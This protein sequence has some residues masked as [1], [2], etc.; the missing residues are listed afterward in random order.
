MAHQDFS[1]ICP[2][3]KEGVERELVFGPWKASASADLI[4]AVLPPMGR[5]IQTNE[6]YLMNLTATCSSSL[7]VNVFKLT[8]ASA[9][10][11]IASVSNST[12]TSAGVHFRG[13]GVISVT[14]FT[15]TDMIMLKTNGVHTDAEPY[16][17]VI[18]YKDK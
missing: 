12:T 5:E 4:L 1:Q 6:A 9:S 13:T 2:I 15:S 10:T 16:Q 17:I 11:E 8:A 7:V 18:R 14:S 3:F